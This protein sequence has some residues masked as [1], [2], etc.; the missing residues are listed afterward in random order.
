MVLW[1]IYLTRYCN[2]HCTYCGADPVFETIPHEPQYEL[3]KLIAFLKMDE[4]PIINF[5]GGEP[6]IRIKNMQSIMDACLQEIPNIKFVLQTNGLLLSKIPVNYIDKFHSILVSIDGRPPITNNYR[7]QKV[8]QKLKENLHYIT[9][10]C[11]FKGELIARMTVSRNSDIFKD[12]TYLLDPDNDLGFTHVHWQ[13]DALWNSEPWSDFTT[14]IQETYNTGLQHLLTWWKSELL[15]RGKIHGIVPFLGILTTLLTNSTTSLRCG[16]GISSYTI[17]TDG[18]IIFCPIGPEEPEA[19]V[20]T[21]D[22]DVKDLK[23][24]HVGEPC[25]SCEVL[26]ICGGRCLYTNF[27]K[28]GS[29]NDYYEVCKSTKF[30]IQNLEQIKSEIID[31]RK[32]GL[33]Q[34]RDLHYPEIN[35]GTEI[36]P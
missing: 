34:E 31:A 3:Q 10:T 6:L 33:I 21:L 26:D 11:N 19:I 28:P 16:A 13:L 4:S 32:K 12:V 5:Y 30:L 29:E 17:S 9:K 8:F 2:L 24:V 27:F 35:N 23:K 25:T 20:G 7:G 36:I 22:S 14:W 1:H 15:E 18:S